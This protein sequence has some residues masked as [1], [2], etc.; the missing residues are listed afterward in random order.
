MDIIDLGCQLEQEYRERALAAQRV[1]PAM[2]PCGFCYNCDDICFAGC[3]CDPDCRD[4][5]VKR[6][7]LTVN[8]QP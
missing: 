8:N 4:D 1:K 5:Y 6:Y 7:R 2:Q 3:F